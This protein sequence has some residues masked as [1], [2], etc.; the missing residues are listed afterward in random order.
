[1][2]HV[3]LAATTLLLL[4]ALPVCAQEPG[5]RARD[6]GVPLNGVT[7]PWNAITDVTGVRVGHATVISDDTGPHAA[8]TG[9][10]AV[11][12]PGMREGL[13]AAV[14]SHNGDG[15]LTGAFYIEELG[16]IISPVLITNTI[17]VGTVH[18]AAIQWSL[19][20]PEVMHPL[21]LPVVAETWDGA[22]NDIWGFH[23]DA[24]H[25]FTALDDAATGPVDEGNVGGGT[26]M[27]THD[28]KA[29]IGTASRV[30]P[31]TAGGY[32][33]G[34]LVQSNYG[35]RADLRV[36]GV[37]VGREIPDLMPEIRAAPAAP[38]TPEEDAGS[39]VPGPERDGS[40]IVVLATDAPLLPHQLQ[41][42]LARV[43]MGLART[44]SYSSSGSG[45][46]FVGFSTTEHTAG[47][48]SAGTTPFLPDRVINHV[49]KAV[50]QATEEAVLNALVAGETM[51]GRNG[52]TIHALPHDRLREIL[53]RYERLDGAR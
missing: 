1:M 14:H 22:L 7:G 3:V 49:F 48:G 52:T 26:G 38:G 35:D 20:R 9:V 25:V 40:V 16:E 32:T 33:V 47:S 29:G 45:D 10:T 41:R 4:G 37:P 15:E 28:F 30:L 12:H 31:E 36:A 2:R 17:S 27:R 53:A 39:P 21:A 5:P 19:E 8:R 11:I 43:P 18:E 23:V 46:I 6:L 34:I 42:A 50:I 13:W 24:G 51:T 44:G